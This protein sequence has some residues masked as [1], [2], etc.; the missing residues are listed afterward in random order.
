MRYNLYCTDNDHDLNVDLMFLNF[1]QFD[2]AHLRSRSMIKSRSMRVIR[3]IDGIGGGGK[4]K[5][6]LTIWHVVYH[7]EALSRFRILNF[8]S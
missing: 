7:F 8:S 1:V 2:C 6:G 5:L 3:R 4:I